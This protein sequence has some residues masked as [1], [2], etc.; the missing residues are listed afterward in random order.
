MWNYFKKK[1]LRE[2]EARKLA[3]K[4]ATLLRMELQEIEKKT[5]T[6]ADKERYRYREIDK[7][8]NTICPNC[9]GVNVNDRIKRQQG[10]I[11][12]SI[13]GSGS[14]FL[15][16]GSSSISGSVH[17]SLDTNEVNKCNDCGHEWKKT[18]RTYTYCSDVYEK[19]CRF[20]IGLC[21]MKRDIN[22]C[23]YDPLDV[24]EKYNSKEEKRVALI[25]EYNKDWRWEYINRYW[26]GVSLEAFMVLAKKYLDKYD[27]EKLRENYN[28]DVLRD[29]F[30]IDIERYA[31]ISI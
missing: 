30:G 15:F 8:Y 17:G 23:N 21:S 5:N 10:S 12:G 20:V 22:N 16:F 26:N 4:K 2:E 1:R 6:I 18:N 31:N 27:F 28:E 13:H 19:M 7:R 24:N 25:R 11:E 29:T 3:E 14:S 9:R